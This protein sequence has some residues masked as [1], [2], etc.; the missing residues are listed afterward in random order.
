MAVEFSVAQEVLLHLVTAVRRV[1]EKRT[2]I[3]ILSNVMVTAHADGSLAVEGTDLDIWLRLETVPGTATVVHPGQST[4]PASLLADILRKIGRTTVT[5]ESDERTA[6]LSANRAWFKLLEL[7]CDDFPVMAGVDLGT[8][9]RFNLLPKQL[10][11]IS[12][13]VGFAISTEETRYYLNGVYLHGLAKEGEDAVPL[14]AVATDGH[15]MSRLVQDVDADL[16][17]MIG[18]IVPR[19]TVGLFKEMA[20]WCPDGEAI[21]VECDATKIGFRAGGFHLVSKLID[22]TFPDYS[23]VIP[24]GNPNTVDVRPEILAGA[25][26]RV[27][28]VSSE[29]GRAV[30]LEIE[31]DTMAL[32]VTSPDAGEARED[33]T[34]A[35]H[36]PFELTIGFNSAYIAAVLATFEAEHLRFALGDPGAAA[37]ITDP[38]D[39]ARLVVLMPMRV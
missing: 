20:G 25:V 11:R 17:E 8:A 35:P 38:T 19:K 30:K 10:Q 21:E 4:V 28:T 9:T 34:V 36:E 1:A 33:I 32:S 22:G 5:Y 15:R 24:S 3:P 39:D 12:S 18:I 14:C 27:S 7:P 29:R 2:T 6:T 23:R 37:L 26:D 13:E 31:G 16:S